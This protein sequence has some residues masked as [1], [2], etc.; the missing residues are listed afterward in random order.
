[1]REIKDSNGAFHLTSAQTAAKKEPRRANTRIRVED[2]AQNGIRCSISS[3]AVLGAQSRAEQSIYYL[4]PSLRLPSA[5]VHRIRLNAND[6]RF[7][8]RSFP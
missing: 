7:P 4:S 2:T 8:T 3:W 1:M 5:C 6:K